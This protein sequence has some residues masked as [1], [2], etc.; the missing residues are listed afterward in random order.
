MN[1]SSVRTVLNMNEIVG[2]HHL[3]LITLDSL[4]YD[5]AQRAWERGQTPGL[6]RFLP[7]QGWER[8]HTP[9][10][11]TYP[12]HQAFF[13]GFLPTPARPGL[14]PRLFAT[15]FLGATTPV[16][17]TF[18]FDQADIVAGLR[19]QG[20]HTLCIGGV[21]FFN[22][23]TKLSSTFPEMFDES[24]WRE[25]FGVTDPRS[26]QHQVDFAIERIHDLAAANRLFLFIN[27]SAIHQ[28]NYFY[29]DRPDH[30]SRQDSVASQAAALIYVDSHLPRLFDALAGYG[31]LFC[32]LCADH[33]EAYGEDGFYG[34]RLNHEVV[35]TVPYAHFVHTLQQ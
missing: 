10:N 11:F 13:A 29:L 30:R 33:G 2:S 8:R 3:V 21:G 35:L 22:K 5:V 32:I 18:I 34:H 27:I 4:R 6:A 25:S 31:P 24:H 26:A 28:P 14:H 16:D 17:E 7:P 20:Y 19:A 15:R 1:S 12:A 9:G 23:K